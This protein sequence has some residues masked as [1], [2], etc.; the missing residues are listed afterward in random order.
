MKTATMPAV[1]GTLELVNKGLET[2]ISCKTRQHQ[3]Y[4]I[5]CIENL[6]FRPS[7]WAA[8]NVRTRETLFP[9]YSFFLPRAMTLGTRLE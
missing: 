6:Y 4:K 1:I 5:L 8:P 9:G 2:F 7:W 3:E